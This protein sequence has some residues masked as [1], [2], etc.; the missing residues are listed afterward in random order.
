MDDDER[1]NAH[2]DNSALAVWESDPS[3][4][5]ATAQVSRVS[6]RVDTGDRGQTTAGRKRIV[7]LGAALGAAT[8]LTI[9]FMAANS[10]SPSQGE[11]AGPLKVAGDATVAGYL[12]QPQALT[13]SAKASRPASP[14]VQAPPPPSP[15]K[16]ASSPLSDSRASKSTTHLNTDSKNKSGRETKKSSA[17]VP[18]VFAGV[19]SMILK[20]LGT[21][22]CADVPTNDPGTPKTPVQQYQC[23]PG[24]VDNQMW[25]LTVTSGAKGPGGVRLFV[26]RNTKDG[27]CMDLPY[28]DGQSAGTGVIE[29][30]CNGTTGDNQLWYLAYGHQNHYQI[31]NLASHG[32]CLGVAGGA[33][34]GSE[35][36]LQIEPC[37]SAA[38]DWGW[39]V[40]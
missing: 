26:I 16:T 33:K 14:P 28:N 6:G 40:R 19:N 29:F 30:S 8:M 12:P 24:S 17:S 11:K 27:L 10:D 32:L 4:V 38:E 5:E 34:A 1:R 3:L 37:G 2:T 36:R 15:K 13:S 35:A 23:Q 20:N 39:S 25:N 31:R 7:Y 9:P 21:G 18:T 22:Y